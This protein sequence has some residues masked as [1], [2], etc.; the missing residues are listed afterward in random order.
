MARGVN[1]AHLQKH[2]RAP[3]PKRNKRRVPHAQYL[4]QVA[5]ARVLA[6]GTVDYVKR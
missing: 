3:K 1:P 4:R 2:P 5:T 6:A